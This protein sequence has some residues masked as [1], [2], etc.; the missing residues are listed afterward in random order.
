MQIF[1]QKPIHSFLSQKD[2]QVYCLHCH[3]ENLWIGDKRPEIPQAHYEKAEKEFVEVA[4]E[5]YRSHPNMGALVL[6][7]TG[8]QVFARAVQR[9]IDIPVFSWGTLLDYAYSVT[10]H[11]DFYGHV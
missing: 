4:V 5:F 11:R 3:F 7:C 6:E 10:V 9:E 8:F 2:R 1:T